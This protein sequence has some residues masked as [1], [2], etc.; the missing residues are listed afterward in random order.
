MNTPAL[1]LPRTR[2][3]WARA[4]LWL[5]LLGPFFFA[6]YGFANWVASRRV[7]VG[8]IVFDWE[9]LI[10]FLPWTIVPYWSIDFFYGLSL[11]LCR[12]RAELDAHA[13]R[14]LSA[15]LVSV[16]CFLAFPLHFSF[17]RPDAGPGLFGWMFDALMG[18]DKPFNQMPSLHISLLLI[19]WELYARRLR[20]GWRLVLHGWSLLIGV[21]V[22]TTW[23]HHFVDIP[24]GMAAGALCMW[25]W[26]LD[27][28]SPLAGARLTRDA[29][30]RRF[31]L[32]YLA[33]ALGFV[34]AAVLL[35]GAAL[36]LF[37]PALALAGVALNYALVG[38]AGFQ[39]SDGRLSAA[40]QMLLAPYLVAAWCNSRL[41]TW[42][43]PRP[44]AI[45]GNVWLGRLPSASE[46]RRSEYQGVVDLCCE[47]PLNYAPRGYAYAGTLDLVVPALPLLRTAAEAIERLRASGPVLVCCALGYSRSAMAICAWLIASGRAADVEGALAQVGAARRRVVLTDEHTK[48][49]DQWMQEVKSAR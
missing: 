42:R 37:W 13:R 45:A 40:V 21:S 27:G 30:R 48:V 49:L 35:R 44:V 17:E 9:R 15:Q 26:P 28:A 10:P 38:A 7:E 18:F 22:L 16:S 1:A 31:A 20:G 29:R 34:L 24:S 3:P 4:A 6:S 11:F 46:L 25:L 12:D 5:V 43:D 39:K 47:L 23:Q 33:G 41:W 8:I 19:L 32:R 2:P 36:W 14:L